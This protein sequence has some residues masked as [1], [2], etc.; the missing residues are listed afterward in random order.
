MKTDCS[1]QSVNRV[2]YLPSLAGNTKIT[3]CMALYLVYLSKS[4]SHFFGRTV[5]KL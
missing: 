2:K 3:Q 4:F 5:K 1:Q